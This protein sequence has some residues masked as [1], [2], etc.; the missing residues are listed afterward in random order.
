MEARIA[1]LQ[2]QIRTL[3]E[4]LNI[5]E[6][7]Q[8]KYGLDV[9]ISLLNELQSLRREL[10]LKEKELKRLLELQPHLEELY[11]LLM[12]TMRKGDYTKAINIC[13]E[14]TN[15]YP[16]YKDVLEIR[17]RALNLQQKREKKDRIVRTIATDLP[18]ISDLVKKGKVLDAKVELIHL[19]QLAPRHPAL[20]QM[21]KRVDQ[22]IERVHPFVGRKGAMN[23]MRVLSNPF[24]EDKG[25]VVLV[26]GEAGVGKTF[27]VRAFIRNIQEEYQDV[28]A[29]Y[30]KC[31]PYGESIL[32]YEPFSQAL[33]FLAG[34]S[35]FCLDES[36]LSLE[37]YVRVL[38]SKEQF[39][40][41]ILEQGKAL[42]DGLICLEPQ[43]E[44]TGIQEISKAHF[45]KTMVFHQYLSVIE[46]I[47]EEKRLI[48]VLDDFQWAD[49]SSMQLFSYL[50]HNIVSSR[51]LLIV[52][53][54]TTD[55]ENALSDPDHLFGKTLLALKRKY[56]NI[57]VNISEKIIDESDFVAS[58]INAV[59]NP[60]K[61]DDYFL[62]S[63][64][65]HTGN[66]ALF[67]SELMT[68][69]AEEGIIY[70]DA[71]GSWVCP[72]LLRVDVLPAKVESIIEQRINKLEGE[73]REILIS[74]SVE[75]EEFTAQV[76]SKIQDIDERRILRDL[77]QKL[78][79]RY[80]LVEEQG[81]KTLGKK[82][83]HF[84]RFKHILFQQ[85]LYNTLSDF[86]K[87]LL[88]RD[89]G[90]CLE[91]L[92]WPEVES[93]SH[94]LVKHFYKAQMWDKV[95]KYG[96]IAA[97]KMTK[98]FAYPEAVKLYTKAIKAYDR[99]GE[100]LSH[101]LADIY[102]E[103]GDVL[104]EM[105]DFHRA[106]KDYE[107]SAKLGKEL[108]V[109]LKKRI[110]RIKEFMG[111]W[112]EAFE[113]YQQCYEYYRKRDDRVSVIETEIRL[114]T[115]LKQK[116]EWHKSLGYLLQAL[117]H[118][119]ELG[120][121]Y[122]EARAACNVAFV[123]FRKREWSTALKY[124]Q[125]DL[126]ISRRHNDFVGIERALANVGEVYLHAGNVEEAIK[127]LREATQFNAKLGRPSCP[128]TNRNLGIAHGK[129][130]PP[131]CTQAKRYLEISI[132]EALRQDRLQEA[133]WSLY[134]LG[135]LYHDCF[136]DA[137]TAKKCFVK[138][139]QYA[140]KIK[141][142]WRW[143]YALFALGALEARMGRK[144]VA[145]RVLVKAH[146]AAAST[147]DQYLQEQ[148]WKVMLVL[149]RDS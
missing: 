144:E 148:I 23:L 137:S 55:L 52:V 98:V 147:D 75:G 73:L 61:F 123:Y 54:R 145:E 97:R 113:I 74:A 100:V 146:T 15:L 1:S 45:D 38:S 65:Q 143:G 27:F 5:I 121:E 107:A 57:E 19:L 64:T 134:E 122:W 79:R 7:R 18:R 105:E 142:N 127:Y 84:F 141:D 83:L 109:D 112:D 135:K 149:R 91:E 87:E 20:V 111:K 115:I 12:E 80:K 96:V 86:E 126:E 56:G 93:I 42:I 66:N 53:Y 14:I 104:L 67:L 59:Y 11:N 9:P 2:E 29:A 89:V 40:Q 136:D 101:N 132:K 50:A 26:T 71:S 68:Y 140:R 129:L 36:V 92:Y 139:A 28:I 49:K 95:V 60:N 108:S 81:S 128:V 6:I 103:R 78:E 3:R 125:L 99:A 70:Q 13:D 46:K 133:S 77:A 25:A 117:E 35:R 30:G 85:Y 17:I 58:Y 10:E 72:E 44:R 16:G 43:G 106:L 102:M 48:I 114:G 24:W 51:V 4:N 69:L 22:A 82:R 88:H 34:D 37:N 94:V 119:R 130:H 33:G 124:H 116:G 110:G 39:Y 120:D 118:A 90:L 62:H 63:I 32:A 138:S 31:A 131:D 8:A 41:I 76:L 21:A 47:A